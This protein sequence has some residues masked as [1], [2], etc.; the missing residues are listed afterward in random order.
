MSAAPSAR[1]QP[2]ALR[3]RTRGWLRLYILPSRCLSRRWG[4]PPPHPRFPPPSACLA[5]GS[6][7][8]ATQ[9]SA[10]GGCR[11]HTPAFRCAQLVLQA[12]RY[13]EKRSAWQVGAAAPTPQLSAALGLPCR[14]LAA[15]GNELWGL[16]PRFPLRSACLADGSLPRATKRLAGG[17]S[18]PNTPAFRCARLALQTARCRGQR[19]LGAAAPLSAALSLPCRRH[20]TAGNESLG[21]WGQPPQHP[22]IPL[23]SACL[24]DGSLTRAMKRLAGR[25]CRPRTPAFRCARL[26]LQKARYCEKTK[27]LPSCARIC[28]LRAFAA[29][30]YNDETFVALIAAA[31]LVNCFI[32][33]GGKKPEPPPPRCARLHLR[34]ARCRR[35]RTRC[36]RQRTRPCLLR[37][38]F[39]ASVHE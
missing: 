13:R 1:A 15:A 19:T 2:G 16:R 10:V 30:V 14:R 39:H 34:W 20:A 12:A 9:R 24:A 26:V 32:V 27:R 5:D 29:E 38:K 6:L 8:R 18:R 7:P 21:R 22:R 4:L 31:K 35:Q 11:S 33:V 25:G 28:A 36:R 23:R 3:S 37:V 17:G